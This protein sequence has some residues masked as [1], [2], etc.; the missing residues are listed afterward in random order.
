MRDRSAAARRGTRV[1]VPRPVRHARTRRAPRGRLT[2]A[3]ALALGLAAGIGVHTGARHVQLTDAAWVDREY[4]DAALG[5]RASWCEAGLYTTTGRGQLFAANTA[6]TTTAATPA[7]APLR[8]VQTGTAS[9]ATPTGATSLGSDGYKHPLAQATLNGPAASLGSTYSFAAVT[10]AQNNQ[11]AR[12]ASTGL[13]SGA[14]GAVSDAGVIDTTVQGAP[15]A[16]PDL[17]TVDVRNLVGST[18]LS[19]QL[20]AAN[21]TD[22]TGV[23]LV[24]RSVASLTTRNACLGVNTTSRAYGVSGLRLEAESTNLRAVSTTA[25]SSA[26]TIQ[27][28]IAAGT[29]AAFPTTAAANVNTTMRNNQALLNLMTPAATSTGTLTL[30]GVNVPTAVSPLTSQTLTSADGA[31]RLDLTNGRMTVDLATLTSATTG[32]NGLAPNSE[33]LTTA[34]MSAASTAVGALLPV[35]QTSVLNAISTALN[36]RTATL[37][38]DTQ[39]SLLGLGA[40]LTEP[41]R[42][43]F[44]GT[45]NQLYAK[46]GGTV[47]VS[48]GT[49]NSCGLLTTGSCTTVRNTFGDPAGQEQLK[50]AVADALATTV[51]GTTSTTPSSPA[52]LITNAV[53]AAQTTLQGS[54]ANLPTAVS[55]QVNVRPDV[56]SPAARPGIVF[57][58]GEVGV[59]ALRIGA[60]PASRTAWVAFGASAAG[61]NTYRLAP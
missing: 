18:L 16:Q 8:V 20:G 15:N 7:L 9:S 1:R 57:D 56:A 35:Y 43:T 44:T 61:P 47:G 24:P 42:F 6:G 21:A 2:T 58:S 4:V 17:A 3:V 38:V 54:L 23:R 10:P 28:A 26:T 27:N 36:T 59:T 5:T 41:T 45:L 22:L 34:I 19:T 49:N 30:T 48:V 55:A 60:V 11:L 52:R 40:L 14:S 50:Q 31:V 13:V 12:A 39:I 46:T 25:T 53:T 51:Y 29:T 37:T 33:V 32:V